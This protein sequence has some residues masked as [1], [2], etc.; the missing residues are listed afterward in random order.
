MKYLTLIAI[1][2]PL[3][4]L[5]QFTKG[6]KLIGGRLSLYTQRAPGSPN[7][8]YAPKVIDFSVLPEIGIFLNEKFAIGG[9]IGYFLRKEEVIIFPGTTSNNDSHGIS[10]GLFLRRYFKI[11]DNFFISLDGNSFYQKDVSENSSSSETKSYSIGVSVRP[12]FSFLPSKNWGL[13]AGIGNISFYHTKNETFDRKVDN[14]YLNYG[15]LN[16][17]LTYYFRREAE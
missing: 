9:N 1:L 8:S 4:S 14:F 15:Q 13:E 17:G 2:L 10:V 5:G 12:V 7:G 16:F 11:S 6:D 3:T